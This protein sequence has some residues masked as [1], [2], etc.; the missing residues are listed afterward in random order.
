LC[1]WALE[2]SCLCD[3][4]LIII[5]KIHWKCK[6]LDYSQFVR[7]TSTNCSLSLSLSL[8]FDLRYLLSKTL[9]ETLNITFRLSL[10]NTYKKFQKVNTIQPILLVFFSG[11]VGIWLQ[12][13]LIYLT[14]SHKRSTRK[15]FLL[16]L[17]LVPVLVVVVLKYNMITTTTIL[18][19]KRTTI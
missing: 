2:V 9:H 1:S 17:A 12:P 19:L 18:P 10:V 15:I 14:V 16:I 13:V 5:V 3:L 6:R 4:S 7:E 11:L 8:R